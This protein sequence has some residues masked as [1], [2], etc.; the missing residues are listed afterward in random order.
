MEKLFPDTFIKNENWEYIW[1]DNVKFYAVGFCCI[2][3]IQNVLKSIDYWQ[4]KSVETKLQIAC[5]HLKYKSFLKNKER[6]R[7]TASFPAW[8]FKRNVCLVVFC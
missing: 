6:S 4:S 7:L 5:F 2:P 1:I 3:S 8:V